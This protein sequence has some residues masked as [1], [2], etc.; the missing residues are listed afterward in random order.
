M[1][2]AV[3]DVFV[4]PVPSI[5]RVTESSASANNASIAADE[6]DDVVRKLADA[7]S[8]WKAIAVGTAGVRG[9]G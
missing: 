1:I 9:W 8:G 3:D 7:T 2:V 4:V 5:M 6:R